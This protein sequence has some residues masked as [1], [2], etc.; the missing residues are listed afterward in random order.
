MLPSANPIKPSKFHSD[1]GDRQAVTFESRCEGARPASREIEK[2]G[3]KQSGGFTAIW[4]TGRPSR[5]NLAVRALAR[6]HA[7]LKNVVSS[8][9]AAEARRGRRR[10]DFSWPRLEALPLRCEWSNSR[11]F[12]PFF[13]QP[14]GSKGGAHNQRR[15]KLM[16]VDAADKKFGLFDG[17][18]ATII[19]Q[20]MAGRQLRCQSIKKRRQI[21]LPPR[22][23]LQILP[24]IRPSL[25]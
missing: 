6:H 5:L 16:K 15:P 4:V 21:A 18:H 22:R 14:I 24:P 9:A 20:S 13:F 12:L 25:C 7:K 8:R 3:V 19:L 10:H 2:C 1:L 17:K 23:D 11:S